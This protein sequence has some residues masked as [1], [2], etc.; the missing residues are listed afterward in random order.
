MH[1]LRQDIRYA[2][3]GFIKR[4]AFTLSAV[5]TLALGIGANTAIFTLLDKVLIRQLPVEQ[6]HQLVTFVG[7]AT[8]S[9]RIISYPMYADLR[10]RN[11]VLAGLVASFQRPFSLNDGN[12]SQ[13]VIGQLVS[14][15]YFAVLGVQPALGRFFIPEEDRPPARI[16]SSSSV[17]ASGDGASARIRQ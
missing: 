6:P 1:G 8:G 3:R 4:P 10:D 13:R 11:D 12:Q 15:N 5:A 7:D 16:L 2:F 14:G 9:P 17:T